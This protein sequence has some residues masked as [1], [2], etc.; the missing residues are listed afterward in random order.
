[1]FMSKTFE[2]FFNSIF[3]KTLDH[4]FK[5]FLR[6]KNEPPASSD[7]SQNETGTAEVKSHPWRLCPVG[8]HWVNS[9]PLT[10]PSNWRRAEYIT[11]RRGHC[12]Q[13][14][15]SAELSNRETY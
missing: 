11:S 2:K 6:K 12:R 9:L 7:S 15:G 3:F 13:N 10:I 1:M 14:Q 5:K 8:K 4:V